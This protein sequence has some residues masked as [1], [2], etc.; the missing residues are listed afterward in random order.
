MKTWARTRGGL[1]AALLLAAPGC[2]LASREE[3]EGVQS[4][5]RVLQEQHQ[6][7]LAE[8]EN[9]KVHTRSVEDQLAAAEQKLALA[10][11]QLEIQRKQM[12]DN[13]LD[14]RAQGNASRSPLDP[15]T[16]R[17]LVELAQSC[18]ALK[19]DPRSGVGR[20]DNDILF[21]SGKA[22]L[23]E[24]AQRALAGLLELL[25]SPEGRDLKVLVVGHT[26][27]RA[28]GRREIREQYADNFDLSTARAKAV[29]D[30][31]RRMGLDDQRLGV[32]GFGAQ[33]PLASNST[34]RDRQKNRRVEIFVMVPEAPVVG[35]TETVP[36]LYR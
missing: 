27:D 7:H 18:P 21:D 28:I 4:R 2:V 13:G 33:Q 25:K 36:G 31:L 6:A 12:A 24:G 32:A 22:E 19:F 17:R 26:D 35:W 34:P 11:Q 15:A 14:P 3:L 10:D 29:A 20:L 8:I 16:S 1:L 9:L 23:K 30:Q 5:N